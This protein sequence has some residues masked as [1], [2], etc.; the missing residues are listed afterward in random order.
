MVIIPAPGF[1]G[2]PLK[3]GQILAIVT[4]FIP[5]SVIQKPG[6]GKQKQQSF[7][8]I[9]YPGN[10]IAAIGHLHRIK[11]RLNHRLVEASPQGR[12]IKKGADRIAGKDTQITADKTKFIFT[13]IS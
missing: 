10:A 11:T 4:V 3:A 2:I 6:G 12:Q 13:E 1:I 5:F 7:G 8:H 9:F